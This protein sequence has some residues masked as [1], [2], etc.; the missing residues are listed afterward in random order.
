MREFNSDAI[1]EFAKDANVN[2]HTHTRARARIFHLL[3]FEISICIICKLVYIFR[4]DNMKD[5]L[6]NPAF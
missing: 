1:L 4:Y 5:T 6:F 3:L 2:R